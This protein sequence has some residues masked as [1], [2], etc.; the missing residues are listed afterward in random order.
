MS[1]LLSYLIENSFI[2][3]ENIINT[4]PNVKKKIAFMFD[5]IILKIT[6]KTIVE[7]IVGTGYHAFIIYYLKA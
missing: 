5:L 1:H 3:N 2:L 7:L 6:N 4:I